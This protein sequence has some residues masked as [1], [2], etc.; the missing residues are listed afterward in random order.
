MNAP[1]SCLAPESLASLLHYASRAPAGAIV[2]IGV[3][4]GG[5]A[6]HLAKVARSKGERVI[7]FDTFAGMPDAGELDKANPVGKF[8]DTSAAE[9]QALIPDAIIVP[10]VFPDTLRG[11]SM[12]PVGFVHADADNYQVTRAI[13]AELPKRMVR[14]GFILFDD[15]M[16]EGCDGCTEAIVQSPYRVL[17][18]TETGKALVVV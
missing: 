1:Y 15:F 8:C 3:Y 4:K 9:V 16:V 17:V 14:G 12:P 18:A 7:L 2:E 6:W 11:L 10:G 5:S 13:L